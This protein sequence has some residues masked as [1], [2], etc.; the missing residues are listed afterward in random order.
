MLGAIHERGQSVAPD[1]G[2]ALLWY[3]VA[4]QNGHVDAQY[5][6]GMLGALSEAH[7]VG[8]RGLVWVMMAAARGHADA[9]ANIAT[10]RN[11]LSQAQ[12]AAASQIAAVVEGRQRARGAP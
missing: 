7:V 10:L 5:R 8:I 11:G 9:Q 4:A 1:L 12:V 6:A 3:E 2:V